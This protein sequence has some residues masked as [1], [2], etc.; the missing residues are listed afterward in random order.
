[1]NISLFSQK[2]IG[3]LYSQYLC[4]AVVNDGCIS[5]KK[6]ATREKNALY[7]SI[8]LIKK[9]IL[10]LCRIADL[11]AAGTLFDM[12]PLFYLLLFLLL[13][14]TCKMILHIYFQIYCCL[15]ELNF[16]CFYF[17]RFDIREMMCFD[18]P[19]TQYSSYDPSK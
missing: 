12:I 9:K 18:I 4:F 11:I 16:M 19:W 7:H 15:T 1:M 6:D 14:Q 10:A 2:N 5:E 13:Y 8:F 17:S 3:M